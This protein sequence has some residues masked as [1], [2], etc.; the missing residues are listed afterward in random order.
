MRACGGPIM[1]KFHQYKDE[2]S[3][4]CLSLSLSPCFRSLSPKCLGA[5]ASLVHHIPQYSTISNANEFRVKSEEE[6]AYCARYSS[7][8]K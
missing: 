2:Q 4:C 5:M 1:S 6:L 7:R 3:I 8:C